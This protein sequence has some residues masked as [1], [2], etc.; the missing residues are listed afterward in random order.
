MSPA[1]TPELNIYRVAHERRWTV[2][3]KRDGGVWSKS[4]Q[5]EREGGESAALRAAKAWRDT[6]CAERPLMGQRARMQAVTAKNTTG[7][8]G[9]YHWHDRN[10]NP[11]WKAQTSLGSRTLT[12][13]FSVARYGDA[14]AF[15]LAVKERHL[16]L[17]RLTTP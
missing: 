9:V 16:H 5:D 2:S 1:P 6:T 4:F 12:R 17:D 13:V 8:P 3:I 14:G 7:V 15:E 11:Y 10:G